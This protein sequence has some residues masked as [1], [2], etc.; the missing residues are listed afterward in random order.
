MWNGF[1]IHFLINSLCTGYTDET[2]RDYQCN[3]GPDGRR[4]DA[5]E[6]PELCRGTVDFV[7]TKEYMVS[8]LTF[9][10][11]LRQNYVMPL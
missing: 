7:A 4:R 3:L 8:L 5:D 10:T 2:P 6:R 1:V 11:I 9:L